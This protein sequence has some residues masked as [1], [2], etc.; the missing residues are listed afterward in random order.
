MAKKGKSRGRPSLNA[1]IADVLRERVAAMKP[2]EPFGTEVALAT[3]CGVTRMTV[4]KAVNALVAEGLVER[5]AGV[6]LFV[7]G[8][9]AVTRR[10]RFVAGNLLWNIAIVAA[11]AVRRRAA[12]AGVDVELRDAGGDMKTF[13]AE[14][15]AL[16]GSGV[17]GAVVFSHHSSAF[18]KSIRAV[19]AKDFPLVI[20]DEDFGARCR[21][22][23]VVSDNS[24]GGRLVAERVVR[25]GHRRLAFIGDFESDTVCAR[26]S[27]FSALAAELTGAKPLKYDVKGVARLGDWSDEIRAIVRRIVRSKKCPTAIFC[28]CD[29]IARHA[30]RAFAEEGLFVLQDLSIVGFDDDLIANWTTP[31]LT[32]VR[33]DFSA[34]GAAA[35]KAL[36][37]R[38]ENPFKPGFT[39]KIP[40]SLVVRESLAQIGNVSPVSSGSRGAFYKQV[41]K[42]EIA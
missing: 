32:T 38:I 6:G 16:P 26:W 42:E 37:E 36:I 4:R 18:D 7:R 14:I 20:I 25:E 12:E 30:M 15:A 39:V 41:N 19:A 21:A 10:W 1:R 24:L 22:T 2:G 5:R 23:C 33:Q 28:S 35:V 27:G 13:L 11:S 29:T 34:M 31:A 3:E 40:V 9:H 8:K 17:T